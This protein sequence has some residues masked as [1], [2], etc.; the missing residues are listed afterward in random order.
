MLVPIH[1][2]HLLVVAFIFTNDK[3]WLKENSINC[4]LHLNPLLPS[5]LA[6]SSEVCHVLEGW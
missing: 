5:I 2:L 4:N 1:L 3:I 6:L